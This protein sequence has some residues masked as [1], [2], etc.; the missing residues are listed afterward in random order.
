M[1]S[2]INL[3]VSLPHRL[4]PTMVHSVLWRLSS[5]YRAQQRRQQLRQRLYAVCR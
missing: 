3:M 1:Q 2:L 5:N 4:P